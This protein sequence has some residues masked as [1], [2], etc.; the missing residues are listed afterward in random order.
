MTS[1]MQLQMEEGR[2]NG[3]K[4]DDFDNLLKY[5]NQ[6]NLSELK[7][8]LSQK[9]Q[10]QFRIDQLKAEIQ[11]EK[12]AE[13]KNNLWTEFNKEVF[14][15]L[16]AVLCSESGII[17]A[18]FLGKLVFEKYKNEIF[19]VLEVEEN[20]EIVMDQ[21]IPGILNSLQRDLVGTNLPKII[22]FLQDSMEFEGKTVKSK[23]DMYDIFEILGGLQ[24]KAEE[25]IEIQKKENKLVQNNKYYAKN[26]DKK[27]LKLFTQNPLKE[28]IKL[29]KKNQPLVLK[30]FEFV[31]SLNGSFQ[32]LIQYPF[33][34][35]DKK[36]YKFQYNKKF[37]VPHLLFDCSQIDLNL[38]INNEF[39]ILQDQM[40]Y[41]ENKD[42]QNSDVNKNN[43]ILENIKQ[44]TKLIL[45]DYFDILNGLNFQIIYY[46]QTQF[47]FQKFK[48]RFLLISQQK[49][50]IEKKKTLGLHLPVFYKLI[51]E[52][53][54]APECEQNLYN[55]FYPS[56]LRKSLQLTKKFSPYEKQEKKEN[57]EKEEN[58]VDKENEK[59]L[60][61]KENGENQKDSQLEQSTDG[62]QE[63]EKDDSKEQNQDQEKNKDLNQDQDQYQ[64]N[65]N[66]DL[67]QEENQDKNFEKNQE[68]NE[69]QIRKEK[70]LAIN[71]KEFEEL[72]INSNIC[73]EIEINKLLEESQKQLAQ[74]IFFEREEKD[75][76]NLQNFQNSQLQQQQTQKPGLE[77]LMQLLGE[78]D[79][80]DG[81]G[82]MGGLMDLLGKM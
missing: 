9:Y 47:S 58:Q 44:F 49:Q 78:Q 15:Y 8:E 20:Q 79:Q 27:L 80:E 53:F 34:F 7:E 60:E 72:K 62:V 46:Y 50:E 38:L 42:P 12:S 24:K 55:I 26:S 73:N 66:K 64:E 59:Q 19:E 10:Q 68:I 41:Y 3:Q 74:R 36:R 61:I 77:G 30:L 39:Q 52:E 22:Q 71:Q 31:K 4:K 13:K 82:E 6:Y 14:S 33:S 2:Y 43:K 1:Y 69:F 29:I 65:K 56:R 5:F 63:G 37:K 70:A 28:K 32:K 18:N 16:S 45:L 81:M 11:A 57:Q 21:I 48:N 76:D 23:T 17:Y 54:L 51:K 75:F 35:D 67:G 40:K 25:V